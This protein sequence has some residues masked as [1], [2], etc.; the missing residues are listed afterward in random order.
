MTKVIDIEDRLRLEQKKKAKVEKAKKLEAVRKI[1]QCSRCLA[2][3]ARCGIQ[4]DTTEMY[5]RYPGLTA[6]APFARRST[7]IFSGS[8]KKAKR[9][10]ATGTTANGWP[11][12]APGWITSG[13]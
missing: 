12:G 6:C 1:M 7:M 8:L 9:A 11:C 10:P 4:F 13:P 5:K 3:C 2:R